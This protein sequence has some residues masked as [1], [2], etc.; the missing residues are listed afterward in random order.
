MTFTLRPLAPHVGAE[1]GG[2]DLTRP[3]DEPARRFITKAWIRHGVLLFRDVANDDVVHGDMAQ[4]QLSRLFGD[5]EAS[6]TGI[7]N[8]PANPYLMILQHDP[9]DPAPQFNTRLMVGGEERVGWLGWHWDQSFMPTIVRGA[10]LRM[11]RPAAS[12]G[13]TGFIDAIAAHERLSEAMKAR[14]AGLEVVYHF[15]PDMA[16]GQFGFPPD[17]AHAP[18]V[19]GGS[20]APKMEFPPVVH[21]L[22][23]TQ[24]ETGRQVLKLSPMHSRYVLGMDRAESD[25]LLAELAAHLVDDRHAYWHEWQA[26]DMVVWDN[27][28]VIHAAQGVPPTVKRKALRTTIM[29]DYKV[30]R[31]LDETR[32]V[33]ADLARIV[34]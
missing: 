5:L 28:R 8:D 26:N 25:A 32:P 19:K 15:N 29:G 6:A 18:G 9:D 10:V 7:L 24:Q 1:I 3:L 30:G 23:I 12:G 2:I 22:V 17:V 34:D 31:Y 20:S 27:W 4:M 14:I 33:A 13:Q 21:P 16:S 11:V